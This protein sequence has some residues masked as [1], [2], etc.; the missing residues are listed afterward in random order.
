MAR[1]NVPRPYRESLTEL[2]ELDEPVAAE[3]IR[4]VQQLPPFSAV[5][6][7][8]RV[9][10]RHMDDETDA[11]GAVAALLSLRAELRVTPAR[12]IAEEVVRAPGL[13]LEDDAQAVLAARAEA[14]LETAAIGT[15][16]VAVDLQTRHAKNFQS[17]KILTD[18][19]PVFPQELD[20]GPSGALI[21][22]TLELQTWNRAGDIEQIYV[23][24]D[25]HDLQQLKGVVDRALKK[26]A[27]LR[28]FLT[29]KGLPYFELD[30][31]NE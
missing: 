23:A 11:R 6:D 24:M 15:T 3:L 12:E 14:L 22:E 10:R 28:G 17:A 8:E 20:D 31:G 26:T 30:K 25:E 13:N 2:A 27:A 9:F 18:V 19:R 29:D 5:P 16:S 7:I 4:D 1:I 21:V